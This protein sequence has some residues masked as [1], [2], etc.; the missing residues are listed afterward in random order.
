MIAESDNHMYR[1]SVFTG[2]PY[3]YKNLSGSSYLPAKLDGETVSVEI[4]TSNLIY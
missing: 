3:T 2:T 1:K 4:T